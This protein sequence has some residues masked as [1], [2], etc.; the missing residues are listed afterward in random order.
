MWLLMVL[1][2][3]TV[4]VL[5]SRGILTERTVAHPITLSPWSPGLHYG[6]IEAKS[7]IPRWI[8]SCP[9][10]VMRAHLKESYMFNKV[11]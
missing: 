8:L 3:T 1:L 2:P 4:L 6:K 7:L 9:Q 10:G 11:M 5:R